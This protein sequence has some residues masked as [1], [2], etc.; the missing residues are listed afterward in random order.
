MAEMDSFFS[1]PNLDEEESVIIPTVKKE[2]EIPVETGSELK[3]TGDTFFSSSDLDGSPISVRPRKK[4]PKTMVGLQ[5]PDVP[6]SLEEDQRKKLSDM[7]LGATPPPIVKSVAVDNPKE[8][9]IIRFIAPEKHIA[10]DIDVPLDIT[11]N[12]LIVGLNA[13]YH[14]GLDISDARQCYLS[15]ENPIALIRG[16]KTLG[17]FGIRDGSLIAY[18]R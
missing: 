2:K 12:D 13:A 4:N 1:A 15:C 5:E 7:L 3:E 18:Y 14:L 10:N 9:V 8:R 11:A 16:N 6:D 17:E